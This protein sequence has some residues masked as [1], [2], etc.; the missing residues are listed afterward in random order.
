M[1]RNLPTMS[2]VP[3][4]GNDDDNHE[5][6]SKNTEVHK[7]NSKI[8]GVD[9]ESTGVVDQPPNDEELIKAAM[10]QAHEV[11]DQMEQ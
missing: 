10:E 11:A 4:N 1:K 2:K 5:K 8:T 3:N 7:E 9:K 6:H